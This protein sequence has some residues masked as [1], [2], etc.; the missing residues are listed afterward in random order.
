MSVAIEISQVVGVLGWAT[1]NV[2]W[3]EPILKSD[4]EE[5][6]ECESIKGFVY[7]GETIFECLYKA[8]SSREIE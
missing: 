1:K 4:P 7:D 5:G 6:W 8:W 2:R 3:I